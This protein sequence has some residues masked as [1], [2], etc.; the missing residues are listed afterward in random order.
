MS[1]P[2]P[3]PQPLNEVLRDV[4]LGVQIWRG[5]NTP[6][7]LQASVIRQ[8][9]QAREE[10]VMKLLGFNTRYDQKWELDHCNGRSGE[11]EAGTYLRNVQAAAIKKWLDSVELPP[12]PA[13]LSRSLQRET[14]HAYNDRLRAELRSMAHKKAEAD[15]KAYI[16]A[17]TQASQLDNLQKLLRLIDADPSKAP[18]PVPT[19]T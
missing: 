10:I 18:H 14:V 2:K 13:Q 6:E 1:S 16:N 9:D 12:M 17:L 5:Q 8:L 4:L 11:S 7:S 19:P 15:A 3:I